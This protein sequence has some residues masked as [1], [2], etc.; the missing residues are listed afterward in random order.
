MPPCDWSLRAFATK[1][2]PIDK[3]I[4]CLQEEVLLI[5]AF[6]LWKLLNRRPDKSKVRPQED[7]LRRIAFE[8]GIRLV[9][10]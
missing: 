1:K 10:A 2:P 6:K 4:L 5:R 3:A 9:Q 7:K 8:H